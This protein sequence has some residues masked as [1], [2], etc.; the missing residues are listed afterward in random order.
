MMNPTFSH[1]CRKNFVI[2]MDAFITY[3]LLRCSETIQNVLSKKKITTVF[4]SFLGV[5]MDLTHLET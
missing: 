3:N 5:A 1:E 2:E 4:T